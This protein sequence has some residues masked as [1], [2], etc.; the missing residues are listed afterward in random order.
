MPTGKGI[1]DE[2]H[3]E[4]EGAAGDNHARAKDVPEDT[5]DVDTTESTSQEPPD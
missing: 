5:P 1:Y 2:E 4:K 3:R